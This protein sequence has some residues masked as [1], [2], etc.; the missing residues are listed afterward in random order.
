M[1]IENILSRY[2]PTRE[3]LLQ[4]LHDVQEAD[5]D[6]HIS[7]NAMQL[8]SDWL[9]IPLSSVYGVLKYYYMYS[10]TPRGKYIIR[11][12]GSVVCAM[13]GS[14]ELKSVLEEMA[15]NEPAENGLRFQIE[16]TE[17]LG[18]CEQAPGFMIDDAFY[19][20]LTQ[21]K[22]TELIVNLKNKLL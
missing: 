14:E 13:K 18:H 9:H 3:N 6:H 8:I 2:E 19:G 17:C 15:I 22:A 10:T 21:E 7:M 16:E 11:V 20:D 4:V 5:P 12:C 1:N